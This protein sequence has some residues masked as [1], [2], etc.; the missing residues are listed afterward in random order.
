[1]EKKQKFQILNQ[2]MTGS[3]DVCIYQRKEIRK[4]YFDFGACSN[5]AIRPPCALFCS[6]GVPFQSQPQACLPLIVE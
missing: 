4:V 2:D 5:S 6:A 1:M 3:S